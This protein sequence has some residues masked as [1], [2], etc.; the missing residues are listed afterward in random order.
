MFERLY[1]TESR[2]NAQAVIYR[3]LDAE[4]DAFDPRAELDRLIPNRCPDCGG[5]NLTEPDDE[6][7]IDCLD[8]GIWFNPFHP[9]NSPTIPGNYPDPDLFPGRTPKQ[10]GLEDEISDL[11]SYALR[12]GA[13]PFGYVLKSRIKHVYGGKEY[14]TRYPWLNARAMD[15]R[16]YIG[17]ATVFKHLSTTRKWPDLEV[18]PGI[19]QSSTNRRAGVQST[20]RKSR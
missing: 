6:G 15:F 19:Q 12:H 10:E 13:K 8:C 18:V 11:K 16:Q 9:A 3:L 14:P 7:L 2:E 1:F 17:D 20:G 5:N 4:E